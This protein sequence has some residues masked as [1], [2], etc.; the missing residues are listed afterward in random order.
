MLGWMNY[1]D[2]DWMDE[3]TYSKLSF[4][5]IEVLCQKLRRGLSK[6]KACPLVGIDART[7]SRWRKRYDWVDDAVIS[8]EEIAKNRDCGINLEEKDTEGVAFPQGIEPGKFLSFGATR[9]YLF[10]DSSGPSPRTWHDWRAR[11]YFSFMKI[12]GKV[13]CDP[14]VVRAELIERFAIPARK[15]ESRAPDRSCFNG[16]HEE[17]DSVGGVSDR[18]RDSVESD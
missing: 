3:N 8:A 4:E 2:L 10:P 16:E 13:F 6:S 9:T 15:D 14:N 5:T 12:G 18:D 11:G 17:N 7:L 1:E